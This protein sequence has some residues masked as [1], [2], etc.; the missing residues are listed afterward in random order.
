M[1][2]TFNIKN[3]IYLWWQKH[4]GGASKAFDSVSTVQP[5]YGDLE[6]LV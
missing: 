3:L 1:T 2:I 5:C 6:V 4:C